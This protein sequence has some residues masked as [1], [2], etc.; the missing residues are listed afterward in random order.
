L[1][2]QLVLCVIVVEENFR[3]GKAGIGSIFVKHVVSC[4][5]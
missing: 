3:T 4:I 5:K 2:G 1:D